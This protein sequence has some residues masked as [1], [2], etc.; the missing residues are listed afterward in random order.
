MWPTR[1]GRAPLWAYGD[2][3]PLTPEFSE[4][5]EGVEISFMPLETVWPEGRAD[6]SRIIPWSRRLTSYTQFRRGDVLLPKVTP[7]FEARRTMVADAT[8]ELG[9]ATSEVHVV[10]PHETTDPRWLAYV[11]RSDEFILEGTASLYGVGGLRRIAAQQVSDYA[12]HMMSPDEQRR[13]ADYL[14]RETAE[15]DTMD[16]ELDRL[17]E[18]LRE[19]RTAVTEAVLV[20]G[21]EEKTLKPLWSVLAPVK[22]QGHPAEEVLSVYRDYGVIL[23]D[24]R[25]DN[26]NRTPENVSSYQLVRPG[27]V[28]INKMKAWQGSLGVSTLRG[29]I[30][31]DYQV[32]RP[33]SAAVDPQYL[34]LVLR[35]PQ[36]IPQ[37]GVRSKGIRP[38]QW[39]LYWEDMAHLTIPVPPLDEQRRIAAELDEQTTRIDDMLADASRLK[40]L[41]AER[42]S[43]LITEVVTGKEE[44][45]A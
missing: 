10:R 39:R 3:N 27:D 9:L 8:T 37:Y 6:Q 15:I 41:L 33:V 2:V 44:V 29:I 28:V 22:D 12:V 31:P 19:R 14:D 7:T 36:M 35:S 13:I 11:L 18:T 26:F 25:D 17:V 24:S 23:K 5:A 34:H 16:A 40:A 42:R 32:C 20:S 1:E 30:S 4:L 21:F 43:T 38:A 45:P